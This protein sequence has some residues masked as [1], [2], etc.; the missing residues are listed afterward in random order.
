MSSSGAQTRR[1]GRTSRVPRLRDE[2]AERV[3]RV[4]GPRP[5]ANVPEAGITRLASE[6]PFTS[7]ENLRARA[8][9]LGDDPAC[10]NTIA[11][12]P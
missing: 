4:P 9:G 1:P 2:R 5:S 12:G 10:L 3:E 11:G 7:R 8:S 6:H